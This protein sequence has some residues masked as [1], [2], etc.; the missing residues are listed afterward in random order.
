MK[1]P[2]QRS[3]SSWSEERSPGYWREKPHIRVVQVSECDPGGRETWKYFFFPQ[4]GWCLCCL[5]EGLNFRNC[6]KIN[7]IGL[8]GTKLL[9][10]YFLYCHQL[11]SLGFPPGELLQFPY[12]ESYA[13]LL[14]YGCCFLGYSFLPSHFYASL[15]NPN[16]RVLE[17]YH[18]HSGFNGFAF[19]EN[20]LLASLL[21]FLVTFYFLLSLLS[22]HSKIP[23]S[24][25][26]Q[27]PSPPLFVFITSR[28]LT[29][30][31]LTYLYA[32]LPY[33]DCDQSHIIFFF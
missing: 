1:F 32:S 31:H 9:C 20:Q 12:F 10:L 26:L 4:R 27:P 22:S 14:H 17:S 13:S 3:S 16:P 29:R 23:I 25:H 15:F 18:I 8:S 19:I 28:F 24:C 21:F 33:S 5:F 2:N 6:L 30:L 7:N 11:F